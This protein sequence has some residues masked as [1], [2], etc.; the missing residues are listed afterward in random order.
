[1]EIRG[2]IFDFDGTLMDSMHIWDSLGAAY[3]KTLGI[4]ADDDLNDILMTM[5]MAEGAA[6][7]QS[8]Y[9]VQKTVEE[10]TDGINQQIEYWYFEVVQLKEGVKPLLEH[11]KKQGIKMC[12]ATATD[13]YLV[14]ACLKRNHIFDYFEAIFTCTQVKASKESPLIYL[15]ALEHLNTDISKTLVFEDAL[16]AIQTAK[17]AGFHVVG[18]YDQFSEDGQEEIKSTADRYLKTFSDWEEIL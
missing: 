11:F 14:E 4:T 17:N 16:Y 18:V 1:M 12:I 8:H 6:H 2:A 15:T 7:F 3:L 5:S 10:I 9:K 13:Q